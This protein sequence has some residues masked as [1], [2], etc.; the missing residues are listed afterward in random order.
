M[1]SLVL[2]LELDLVLNLAVER[3]LD[4]DLYLELDLN[5]VLGMDL[6]LI[7]FSF[8]ARSGYGHGMVSWSGQQDI[9]F[10]VP[11]TISLC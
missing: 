9:G 10:W 8:L 5:P 3:A 6:V 4:L 2:A 7:L 1:E 11:K